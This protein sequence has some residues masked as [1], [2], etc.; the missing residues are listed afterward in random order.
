[1]GGPY[2][3]F[4]VTYDDGGFEIVC[5]RSIEEAP[6]MVRDVRYRNDLCRIKQLKDITESSRDS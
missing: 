6:R 1:M 2:H 4:E 5:A 3:C